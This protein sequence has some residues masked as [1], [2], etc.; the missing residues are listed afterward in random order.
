MT[1]HEVAPDVGAPDPEL[2]N[3]PILDGTMMISPCL[4][5]KAAFAT[6]T[7]LA[8]RSVSMYATVT[9]RCAVTNAVSGF[10]KAPVRQRELTERN[11]YIA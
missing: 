11:R 1:D 8:I 5:L 3:S 6:S 10:V 7:T 4:K 2:K 9:S